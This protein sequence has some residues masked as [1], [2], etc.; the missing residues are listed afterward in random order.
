MI[1][2]KMVAL[3][4][5]HLTIPELQSVE[6]PSNSRY[7]SGTEEEWK[8]ERVGRSSGVCAGSNYLVM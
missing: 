3:F 6:V 7:A 8:E 1:M 5:F 4:S 2:V